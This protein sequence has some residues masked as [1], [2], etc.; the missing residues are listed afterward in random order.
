MKQVGSLMVYFL[1]FLSL[2]ILSQ[3]KTTPTDKS[4]DTLSEIVRGFKWRSIG[5]ALMSGRVVDIAVDPTNRNIWYVAAASGGVWKTRNS[6]TTWE[7]IFDSYGSYSIGCVTVDPNNHMVVWVGTGENN[8]QRSVGYGDGVYKS[9]DGGQT[10]TPMGLKESEHIGMIRVDPRDSNVVY[11][12]S[13]GPLWRDGGDRGLY[14]TTD[15][16]KTWEKILEISPKTGVSEIHLDPRNPNI[17]YA[18]A[19]QRRRHVWTLIDGGPESGLYKSTDAGKTWRKINQGLPE[20]D[21]G[22]IGLALSPIDPDVLYATV[23]AAMDKSGFYRSADGGEHWTRMSDYISSSPQYYQEIFADPHQFDRVYAMDTYLMV[24]DDGGKTFRRLGEK[25]KHVDNHAMVFDPVDPNHLIIGTDGGV[26]E[27]WDRGQTYEF[28]ANLPIT[29]FYKIAADNALPFYNVC[30]GTQD[31]A[32][33]CGPSRTRNING[34]MNRDWFITVFGDGFGPA[35]DPE[36]PDII[37]SQWQYGNLIRY[38]KKTGEILDIQPQESAEG[39]PLRWNWN[40]ALIISPH[41]PSRLY[42]GAQVLFRSD[43]RGESWQPISPD[44]TRNLDRNRLP[45]MGRVWSVDAVAKNRSTSF[46]GNIVSLTESPLVENLI[47]AGTDDGLIQVTEDG[48]KNWRRIDKIP[49][50]PEMSYVSDLEASVH[51]PDTLYATFDNHKRGDFKP[52]VLMSKDRGRTWK[53]IIGN[54]PTR[55]TVYTIVQDHVQKELLFVGTEFGVFFTNDEGMNWTQLKGGM[56]TIATLDLVIQRRENDLIAG[57]FG[58]GIYILDDYTPLRYLTPKIIQKEAH[59]F[60]IKKA[61]LYIQSRPLADEE[62]AFQG[63]G[64]FTAPNPPFGAI[65]TYY[66]KESLKTRKDERKEKEKQLAEKGQD[67]FYPSWEELKAEDREEPPQVFLVVRDTEGHVVRRLKGDTEKGIHRIAWNLRLPAYTPVSL[68]KDEDGPLAAPGSYTVS[69]ESLYRGEWK[70]LASPFPFEVEPL[71]LGRLPAPERKA[72]LEFQKRT[73]ELQRAVTGAVESLKEAKKQINYIKRAITISP[74]VPLKLLDEARELEIS[75]LELEEKLF[76]DQTKS[77]RSEPA[78]PG[79]VERVQ[80]VVFG[81]WD[82]TLSPTQTQVKNLDLALET[83]S[84]INKDLRAVLE[85]QLPALKKK[86]DE[87]GVP[88]TPG[89]SIPRNP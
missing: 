59:L 27:T 15:G 41:S 55:G 26:Y 23:E 45:V 49:G 33:Q 12:A 87:A 2:P 30:G 4:K 14:K 38:D 88:W 35:F 51:D 82:T 61:W 8:S 43:D 7:P 86:L 72:L 32:T 36:N 74:N 60:P 17:L 10:F 42:F 3:E 5:P 11:V 39:P 80:R 64:F 63:A 9:V 37:Y 24:T 73:G 13:Q 52:Y 67:I 53:S 65:F 40:S 22:R 1:L 44:L 47:Y 75:I 62:K 25:W 83:F 28:K 31:N 54:L 77:K 6:G 18:V 89:R 19:Y 70:N 84:T 66:L 16:G 68:E 85:Q 50:V 34:I 79:I 29:Q 21:L 69:I 57:T 76:G 20:V 71:D 48:G 81:H 58:R 56:P 78:M 46:Y